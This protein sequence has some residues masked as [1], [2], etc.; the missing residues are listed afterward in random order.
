MRIVWRKAAQEDLNHAFDY[1]LQVDP[2][3]AVRLFETIRSRT[4]QLTAFP[5]LGRPGR[6]EDTRE[7]IIAGTPYLVAYTVDQ[8][9]G[10]VVIL[11]VLHGRQIWPETF[12]DPE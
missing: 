9:I 6:V 2:Q 7:L 1:V 5:G 10:A 4:E 3:A 11:R 12:D 8:R